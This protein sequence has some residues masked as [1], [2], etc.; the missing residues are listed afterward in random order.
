MSHSS[1]KEYLQLPAFSSSVQRFSREIHRIFFEKIDEMSSRTEIGAW[2]TA[3]WRAPA[4]A[5]WSLVRRVQ[6]VFNACFIVFLFGFFDVFK[7]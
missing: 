5:G 2:A 4:P 3:A 1:A 7:C 6:N